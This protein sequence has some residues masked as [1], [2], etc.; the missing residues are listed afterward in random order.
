MRE[1]IR[2]EVVMNKLVARSIGKAIEDFIDLASI[3]RLLR[4]TYKMHG[5]RLAWN[6]G[7]QYTRN[8]PGVPAFGPTTLGRQK[9]DVVDVG[10]GEIL[11]LWHTPKKLDIDTSWIVLGVFSTT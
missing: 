3:D 2:T 6:V 7:R 5:E 9:I 10:G 8:T 11:R 1:P 4:N